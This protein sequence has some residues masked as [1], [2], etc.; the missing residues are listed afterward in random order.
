MG[1]EE[2]SYSVHCPPSRDTRSPQVSNNPEKL[3]LYCEVSCMSKH[4]HPFF[5]LS[6]IWSSSHDELIIFEANLTTKEELTNG[7]NQTL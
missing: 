3:Q 4:G 5:S 1:D 2:S 7:N 6:L